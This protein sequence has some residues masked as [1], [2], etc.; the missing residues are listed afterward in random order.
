MR[1]FVAC[2]LFVLLLCITGAGSA[3]QT[4][5]VPVTADTLLDSVAVV[6]VD[7][8][9]RKELDSIILSKKGGIINEGLVEHDVE[10]VSDYLREH[11]WWKASVTASVDTLPGEP[12]VL[13][14][15]V[16]RGNP[17]LFGMVTY[18][19]TGDTRS[20]VP[21]PVGKLYGA[22]FTRQKL[23]TSI[24]TLIS[25]YTVRGFPDVTV[26]PALKARGDTV[27]IVLHITAGAQ[28][29]IDSIAVLGLSRTRDSVIRRELS[30][31][32]GHPADQDA[33]IRVRSIIERL[34]YVRM[35]DTPTVLYDSESR[36]ILMIE[37]TE[38]NQGTFDGVIGYQP[39]PAGD[40]GEI[41]GKIDLSLENM[42]GTG[43]SS[44]IRW[45]NLGKDTEDLEI[46]YREPWM[47]GLPCS[48]TASFQQE[49][50]ERQGYT[51]TILNAGIGRHIGRLHLD[52]GFRYEKVS[53]DSAHSSHAEG[54][55]LGV[56]WTSL[57]SPGN[58]SSGIRY[59]VSWSMVSKRYRFGAGRKNRLDRSEFDLDHYIPTLSRQNIALLLR[60]RRVDTPLE[61]LGPSDRY[62]L[63]G[64]S[65]I[66]G[67][68]ENIFPAVKALWSSVEYRVLTGEASRAF[69][70][71]DSGY[72][73]NRIRSGEGFKKK[74]E[75]LVGY[76]FG[77]RIQSRAGTLGFDYGLG[78]GDSPGDGKLH[79]RLST[80]F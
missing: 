75:T 33:V 4:D 47:F 11:G 3:E 37:L 5:A 2:I 51:R 57:D 74:T 6:G 72:L 23:D 41:V 20:F 50:R 62:W 80:D 63:G 17:V 61:K 40:S 7:S 59:S 42:F 31:L 55:D 21:P 28:A 27:D 38:G 9:T 65:T 32:A 43:R 15:D 53:A 48:A 64:S 36:S 34:T 58:P 10:A 60:Y 8:I 19:I 14:F 22:P 35:V 56:V 70:F 29:H 78:K 24:Q 46:R 79:V 54:F 66:R 30:G 18:S 76:G 49:Q 26:F 39:S 77:I 25:Y 68:R 67:Y 71:V 12:V 44:L 69:V 45:E 52:G 1:T 13:T 73:I 16:N